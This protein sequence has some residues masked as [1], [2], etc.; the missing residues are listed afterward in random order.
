MPD[1]GQYERHRVE[2]DFL[3]LT[4]CQPDGATEGPKG[5]DQRTD[6]STAGRKISGLERD[7]PIKAYIASG[8]APN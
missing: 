7:Q 4:D 2:R 8:G 5:D 6:S 3:E 1:V